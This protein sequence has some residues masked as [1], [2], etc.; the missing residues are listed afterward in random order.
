MSNFGKAKKYY[1]NSEIE[2]KMKELLSNSELKIAQQN[3]AILLLNAR[4]EK[5]QKDIKELVKRERLIKNALIHATETSKLAYNDAKAKRKAELLRL[6]E[7]LERLEQLK[8]KKSFVGNS[9]VKTLKEIIEDF[10]S[11]AG[12]AELARRKELEIAREKLDKANKD[13][14][15][16]QKSIEERYKTVLEKYEAIKSASGEEGF[17]IEEALNPTA[18]LEEIMKDIFKKKWLRQNA[19]MKNF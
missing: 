12:V 13:T 7:L 9:E 5:Q 19:Q 15:E 16:A 17:S 3:D 6:D 4:I 8:E 10:K 14:K 2:K 11:G 18:S 1:T